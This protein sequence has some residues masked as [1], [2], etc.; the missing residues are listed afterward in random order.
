MSSVNNSMVTGEFP[1]TRPLTRRFDV[2]LICSWINGGVNGGEARDLRRHLAHYDVNAMD[3][4]YLI[5]FSWPLCI[6]PFY[7]WGNHALPER[8]Q[9][10][11]LAAFKWPTFSLRSRDLSTCMNLSYVHPD[12]IVCSVVMQNEYQPNRETPAPL[13]L[14]TGTL[15]SYMTNSTAVMLS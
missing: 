7:W 1:A 8:N 15:F 10:W 3:T 9:L 2:F 12:G 13:C 6:A 11:Y 5:L 14:P 4:S